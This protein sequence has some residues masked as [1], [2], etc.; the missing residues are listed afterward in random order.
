MIKKKLLQNNHKI[1]VHALLICIYQ[2]ISKSLK[3]QS[4]TVNVRQQQEIIKKKRKKKKNESENIVK[5]M[6]EA[7]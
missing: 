5:G 3:K 1:S 6:A 7:S 2:V 4:L